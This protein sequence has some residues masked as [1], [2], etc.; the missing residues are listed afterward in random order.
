[1]IPEFDDDRINFVRLIQENKDIFDDFLESGRYYT[2]NSNRDYIYEGYSFFKHF[3]LGDD[4]NAYSLVYEL[5]EFNTTKGQTKIKTIINAF[6]QWLH[7]D[8]VEQRF[9]QKYNEKLQREEEKIKKINRASLHQIDEMGVKRRT[10]K[11]TSRI[12]NELSDIDYV[13]EDRTNSVK[14]KTYR[15]VRD[16]FNKKKMGQ[17]RLGGGKKQHKTKKYSARNM[18]T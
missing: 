18:K 12:K 14:G 9:K 5:N 13:P 2:S 11:R 6:N 17:S 1:M 3:D 4:A 16:E 15:S 10:M 8:K 7:S